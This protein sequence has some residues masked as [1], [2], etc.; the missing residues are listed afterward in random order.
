L[1]HAA[2][3]DGSSGAASGERKNLLGVKA[4]RVDKG[5]GAH[6][7]GAASVTKVARSALSGGNEA[8]RALKGIGWRAG[9]A[10]NAGLHCA[11]PGTFNPFQIFQK[12]FQ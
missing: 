8:R 9:P 3:R 11:R 7:A 5:A 6:M 1:A 2:E 12:L 10:L 4:M